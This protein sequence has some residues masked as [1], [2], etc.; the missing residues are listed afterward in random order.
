M[1]HT[2]ESLLVAILKFNRRMLEVPLLVFKVW[3]SFSMALSSALWAVI[4]LSEV[5][6]HFVG[7][8][9]LVCN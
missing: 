4:P 3:E 1:G 7:K 8:V 6:F 9:A 5:P 2:K